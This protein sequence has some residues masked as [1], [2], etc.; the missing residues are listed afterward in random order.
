MKFAEKVYRVVRKI[1]RGGVLTYQEIARLV[2]KPKAYR[3]VGNVLNK[4]TNLDIP[5]HRVVKS[6]GDIGGF[7][8][9]RRK[10][11]ALLKK[12]GVLI[13]DDKIVL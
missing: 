11:I 9:G 13:K 4:N 12:E 3:A 6:D 10:K 8:Y 1:P 2:G 7:R 5:C